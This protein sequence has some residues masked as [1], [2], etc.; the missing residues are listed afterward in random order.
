M[1]LLQGRTRAVN[2]STSAT[3]AGRSTRVVTAS[4][5]TCS[6]GTTRVRASTNQR[7]LTPDTR[8]H[9]CTR[10]R[11]FVGNTYFPEGAQFVFTGVETTTVLHWRTNS[12]TNRQTRAHF[13]G[14]NSRWF[15]HTH[16]TPVPS[17]GLHLQASRPP[18][19]EVLQ[20]GKI[21]HGFI[22]HWWFCFAGILMEYPCPHEGCASKLAD[23]QALK[24]HYTAE[25]GSPSTGRFKCPFESCPGRF[26]TLSLLHSHQ[27]CTAKD[28]PTAQRFSAKWVV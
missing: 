2:R 1:V 20:P 13:Q 15:C 3:C 10:A 19:P 11:Q 12:H 28:P 14:G 8:T 16:G 18:D 4:R 7:G 9:T 21:Q 23:R 5:T 27:V 22:L 26:T 17:R 25:H 6:S 24:S